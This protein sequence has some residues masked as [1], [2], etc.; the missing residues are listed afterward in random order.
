MRLSSQYGTYELRNKE[1]DE[2]SNE[3]V[4]TKAPT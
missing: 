1:N 3:H 4:H 2:I